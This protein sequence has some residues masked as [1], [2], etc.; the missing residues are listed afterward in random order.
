MGPTLNKDRG[1]SNGFNGLGAGN[2]G[3]GKESDSERTK[4]VFPTEVEGVQL[5]MSPNS[6]TGYMWR[7]I[8]AT[9][10]GKF[11]AS[12]PHGRFFGVFRCAVEA[13]KV[14]AL[15]PEGQAYVP[16]P[17]KVSAHLVTEIED[18]KLQPTS[19]P[20]HERLDISA[21][22]STQP[23]A[24]AGLEK[25]SWYNLCMAVAATDRRKR[26]PWPWPATCSL[27][28]SRRERSKQ[29]PSTADA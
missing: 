18:E 5:L 25:P 21:C 9:S 4:A 27:L 22:P 2:G 26:Q 10:D 6:S 13:A 1:S 23:R 12:R 3:N 19:Q 16:K 8:R 24:R 14:V 17:S 20:Q 7:K 28:A 15:S 11:R 29:A